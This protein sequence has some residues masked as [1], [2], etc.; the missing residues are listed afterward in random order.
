MAHDRTTEGTWIPGRVRS[1]VG[2]YQGG[3]AEFQRKSATVA[4]SGARASRTDLFPTS[5]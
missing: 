5:R 4:G 1:A 3:A 2:E